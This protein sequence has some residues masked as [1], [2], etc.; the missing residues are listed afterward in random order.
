VYSFITYY[1][2]QSNQYW[3][4]KKAWLANSYFSACLELAILVWQLDSFTA[5]AYLRRALSDSAVLLLRRIDK[6]QPLF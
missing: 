5:K 2:D 1:Q 3:L 6:T 4:T